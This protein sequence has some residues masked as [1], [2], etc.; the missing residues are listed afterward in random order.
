MRK[1]AA[2][3]AIASLGMGAAPRQ[4]ADN[5]PQEQVST[6]EIVVNGYAP[7]CHPRP[8]EPMDQFMQTGPISTADYFSVRPDDA[9]GFRYV[10]ERRHPDLWYTSPDY[11]QRAGMAI[12]DFVFRVPTD[13]TPLC[14]G[15]RTKSPRGWVQLR[16]ILRPTEFRCKFPRFTA[17]VATRR[18]DAMI[19]LNDGKR[20][21]TSGWLRGDH[22][23]TPVKIE[24]GIVDIGQGMVGLGI[25]IEDGDVWV[26]QPKLE[27]IPDNELTADQRDMAKD[28]RRRLDLDR[29]RYPDRPLP[30]DLPGH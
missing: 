25:I 11:W 27:T 1:A 23:W 5:A 30:G 14:I 8:G 7:H 2:L 15:A 12:P 3:L 9:G 4:A 28:C 17:F 16:K 22:G 29:H 13:G 19:W 10:S 26:D 20:Q 6:D 24:D 18:S 21:A